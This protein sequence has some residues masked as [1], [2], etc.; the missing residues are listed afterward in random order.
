MA[1]LRTTVTLDK[2][3]RITLSEEVREA[4][5]VEAGGFILLE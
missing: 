4:L 1:A 3:G 5:G 2:K